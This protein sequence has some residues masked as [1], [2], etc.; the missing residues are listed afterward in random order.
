MYFMIVMVLICKS[1]SEGVK[2][3]CDQLDKLVTTSQ[4]QELV[5]QMTKYKQRASY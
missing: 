2:N 5:E 3:L 4:L 1:S